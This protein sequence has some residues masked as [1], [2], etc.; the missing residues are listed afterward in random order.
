M[1][2]SVVLL[3]ITSYLPIGQPSSQLSAEVCVILTNHIAGG[4]ICLNMGVG[5]RDDPFTFATTGQWVFF[6]LSCQI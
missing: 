3:V 5:E 1:Q 4:G 6:S 2:I